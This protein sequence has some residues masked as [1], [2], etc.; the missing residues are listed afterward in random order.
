MLRLKTDSSSLTT[1]SFELNWLTTD[2]ACGGRVSGTHGRIE[3]PP[4][5]RF[6]AS[7]AG[8]LDCRWEVLADFGKRIQFLFNHLSIQNSNCQ[9]F[10]E[11]KEGVDIATNNDTSNTIMRFCN[12]TSSPEFSVPAPITSSGST[13]TVLYRS[14]DGGSAASLHGNGFQLLYH[15][16][17]GICGGIRSENRG[18]LSPPMK[19]TRRDD[20][21]YLQ[22]TACDWLIRALPSEKISLRFL[23][24]EV[25]EGS[26]RVNGILLKSKTCI[27]DVLEIFDGE[28]TTAPLIARLCGSIL[29]PPVQSTG[30]YLRVKW[31]TDGSVA[32]KGFVAEYVRTLFM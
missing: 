14:A 8:S 17:P 2:R 32:G 13:V 26:N 27:H 28:D 11:L 21:V 20:L 29:P 18:T 30:R 23:S 3:S 10:L 19:T 25:E 1:E 31:R 4:P 7:T 15:Q 24:F 12:W 6:Q 5:R 16:V 22:N 9:N